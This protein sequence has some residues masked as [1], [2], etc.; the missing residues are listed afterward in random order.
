[1]FRLA[2]CSLALVTF[3]AAALYAQP[4]GNAAT[5]IYTKVMKGSVPEYTAITVNSNGVGTYDGRQLNQSPRPRALKLSQSTTRKLFQMAASLG[6]FRSIKLESD[7]KV[8]NMGLKTFV[9]RHDGQE[10]KVQFNYTRNKRAEDLLT[11]FDGVANV[12]QH[13]GRLEFSSRYDVLG[14]PSALTQVEIDLDNNALVD[15]QLMVPILE[16][17]AGD[18]QYLHIAQVRAEDIIRRIQDSKDSRKPDRH[19]F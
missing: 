7:K 14:L 6:D 4:A 2:M 8:A 19:R 12:E 11:M 3:S 15:P 10:N 18:S 5:L 13:I 1:M 16:K 17:I 9:Y